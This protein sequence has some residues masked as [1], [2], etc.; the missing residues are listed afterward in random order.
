MCWE[1]SA[2]SRKKLDLRQ[3]VNGRF[4]KLCC[5]ASFV[6]FPLLTERG[7]EQIKRQFAVW[8]SEPKLIDV[9]AG[10]LPAA[11][12]ERPPDAKPPTPPGV[13]ARPGLPSQN[14]INAWMKNRID[15]W[16]LNMPPPTEVENL[17]AAKNEVGDVRRTQIR[18][19]LKAVNAPIDW[20]KRGPRSSRRNS[21][22]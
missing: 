20:R 8:V 1:T 18:D 7:N 10:H 15:T 19:A 2:G 12:G 13:L 21:A 9:L 3:R 16:P 22:E 6:E 4:P 11:A 5:P 14:R 17:A